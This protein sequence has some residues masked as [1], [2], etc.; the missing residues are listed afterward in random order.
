MKK[1]ALA[2][3]D[4]PPP[5][6]EGPADADVTLIGWGSTRGVIRE[7]VSQLASKG[8]RANHL[9]IKYL[10]PF[11]S[12]TV[13][14]ILS[15]S[16]RTICIEANATGQFARHLRA[17]SGYTVHDR[18]LRYDGE[19]FEPRQITEQV[20][21]IL[22]GR[23]RSLDVTPDEAR[24]IA[25]HYLRVHLNEDVRPGAIEKAEGNGAG[26]ALWRIEIVNRDS[27]GKQGE[28]LV[29]METGSTYSWQ[30]A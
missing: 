26:E 3:R 22:E 18:I 21:A 6:L 23:P 13:S 17:E 1:M 2:L 19:P 30:P 14:D 8:V 9:H 27:G 24:E 15:H 16:K 12:E 20:L 10:Y 5:Q 25:Y 7:S 4:L 11:H 29:G 28:L